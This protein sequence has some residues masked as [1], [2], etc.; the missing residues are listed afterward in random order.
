MDV[1][2]PQ[3]ALVTGIIRGETVIIPSGTSVI[4]PGDHIIIFARREA[5][6]Q[7]EKLLAVKLEYF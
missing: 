7:I 6:P 2:F 3:G 5:I 1:A 4:L